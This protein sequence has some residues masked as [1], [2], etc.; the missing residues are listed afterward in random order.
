MAIQTKVIHPVEPQYY[1]REYRN[2]LPRVEARVQPSVQGS[3]QDS[4]V[5]TAQRVGMTA[6]PFLSLCK[7]LSLPISLGMGA[8]RTY[9]C[10]SVL[11]TTIQ[12]GDAGQI[13]YQFIQTTVAVIALAGTLFAHP[14]GMLITTGH[15]LIVAIAQL[16]EHLQKQ[17]YQQAMEC[18]F[19][20]INNVLYFSLFLHGGLELSIASLTVQI[21]LGIY[22]S[23]AEFMKGNYIEAAGHLGMSLFRGQQLREQVQMLQMQY[24]IEALEKA[25]TK[26]FGI[27]AIDAPS[28]ESAVAEATIHHSDPSGKLK[29]EY[30]QSI[31][32]AKSSIVILTYTFSD[33]DVINLL[34]KKAG[35]GIKV[36]I[37]VDKDHM[38]SLL[39]HAGKFSLLTR[40]TGEGR[41]HHK[42]TVV[43]QES[44]WI[45]SANLSPDALTKQNNTVIRLKSK[46]MA[47]ALH[48]EMEVFLGT[49]ERSSKPLPPITINGQKIELLL[50]PNVPFGVPNSPEKKLNDYGKKR[51]LEMINGASKS[52]RFA[53]CVWTDPDLMQAVIAAKQRGV[54]VEVIVWKKEESTLSALELAGINITQKPHL[55]LMHNKWMLVDDEDFLNCS[56]NW[57]K[58]W[59]SRNDESS[60]IIN[61]LTDQQ[62]QNLL[63][64]WTKLL[65]A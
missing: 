10:A 64:Y 28:G 48:E 35:E 36:T 25:S 65:L 15:D 22:T 41:L 12:S 21:L 58:S 54:N 27:Q 44:V 45:G 56:A 50:F 60:I 19:S 8:A 16:A 51:I 52:L 9:T 53:V 61:K 20:I 11:F 43:D 7:P 24:A 5:N 23:R 57:S 40:L 38:G 42:I 33:P 32:E 1:H 18:C 14:T 63:E 55:P 34:V 49:R 3:D 59:F 37:V 62:R 30:I 17:E 2:D 29:E 13:A 6:L 31:S 4:W 46:E 47:T 39:P 26:S